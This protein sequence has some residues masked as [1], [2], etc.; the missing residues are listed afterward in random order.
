MEN[1]GA[2]ISKPNFIFKCH[3][4]I[5]QG[6]ESTEDNNGSSKGWPKAMCRGMHPLALIYVNITSIHNVKVN[7]Q[8]YKQAVQ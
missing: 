3:V 2:N 7:S 4:E 6:R 5:G 1:K 8:D